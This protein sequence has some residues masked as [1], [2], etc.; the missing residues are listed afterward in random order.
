MHRHG[1]R[2]RRDERGA[3]AVIAALMM[4]PLISVAALTVDVANLYTYRQRLQTGTD[5]TALAIASDCLRGSCGDVAATA[6]SFTAANIGSGTP[7]G[8]ASQSN[9]SVTVTSSMVVKNIFA[10]AI[11][12]N[13]TAVNADATAVY[14]GPVSGTAVL[15]LAV[16]ACEFNLATG[17]RP[18]SD[19]TERTLSWSAVNSGCYAASG[20]PDSKL[21]SPYAQPGGFSWVQPS[22]G[23]TTMSST[24]NE[25]TISNTGSNVPSGSCTSSYF[26]SLQ[27]QTVLLPVFDSYRQPSSS[28]SS[29][30]YFS[31]YG[32]VG[33]HITG[34][35]LDNGNS[36]GWNS[37]CNG[38]QRCL[39]GYFTRLPGRQ[40][41]FTY[42]AGEPQLGAGAVSLTE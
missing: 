31:V 33:F 15:P 1:Y 29:N 16:N 4:V 2:R 36:I 40:P 41:G 12:V 37:S 7:T 5:A 35:K 6:R 9:G 32:Y 34:Y 14:G 25:L 23:C 39:H 10:P 30:V 38:Q 13:T 8:T 22:S 27:G 42:G 21:N 20:I 24:A 3:V 19:T 18:P 28:N 11:G 26:S 17:G